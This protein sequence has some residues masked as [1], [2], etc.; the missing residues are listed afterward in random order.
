[1]Q[2]MVN[3]EFGYIPSSVFHTQTLLNPISDLFLFELVYHQPGTQFRFEPGSLR[4]HNVSCIGNIHQLLHR[5][6]IKCQ[7]HFHFAAVNPSAQF[8]QAADSPYK[9]NP[10][11]RTQIL[12]SQNFVQ[13]QVGRDVTSNTPIGSLSS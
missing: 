11:I 8:A 1:M 4:R 7:S 3:N 10:A 2:F 5:N 6:R 13:N 9:V 12:D